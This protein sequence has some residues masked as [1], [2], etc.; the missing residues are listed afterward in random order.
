MPLWFGNQAAP[1]AS[2]SGAGHVAGAAGGSLDRHG[3]QAARGSEYLL[4]SQNAD[5]GWAA[6]RG[7][8][9]VRGRDGPGRGRPGSLDRSR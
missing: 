2:Q 6:A 9:V 7:R 8:G 4:Q 5:G 3:P 1:G